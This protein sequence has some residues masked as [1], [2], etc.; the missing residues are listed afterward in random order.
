MK[1]IIL[2][3]LF[4]FLLSVQVGQAADTS[5]LFLT[6]RGAT[7]TPTDYQGKALITPGSYIILSVEAFSNGARYPLEKTMVRWYTQG[8][9]TQSGIGLQ[10]F[11][12]QVK[13]LAGNDFKVR[14]EI[15]D[16]PGGALS[17][18]ILI[19]VVEPKV[20]I[21]F[22]F[23]NLQTKIRDFLVRATPYFFD[24]ASEKNLQY[25]WSINKTPLSLKTDPQTVS[26]LGRDIR[27]SSAPSLSFDVSVQNPRQEFDRARSSRKVVF[28][29][30]P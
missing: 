14:V 16:F 30:T 13:L 22:P 24:T 10:S 20:V 28:T 21:E 25:S 9:L 7:Y 27:Q 4:S 5:S 18:T 23:A 26:I 8:H 19:R 17:K 3:F 15:P 1:K 29:D 12:T 6:W 2:I 11:N